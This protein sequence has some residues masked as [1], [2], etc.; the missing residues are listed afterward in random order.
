MPSEK[1]AEQLVLVWL[2]RLLSKQD[3]QF[4][5]WSAHFAVY[6]VLF[7]KICI[8]TKDEAKF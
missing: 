1:V 4:I 8:Y 6:F 2:Q 7:I 3:L 5:E